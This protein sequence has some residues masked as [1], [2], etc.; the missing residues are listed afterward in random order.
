LIV[1]DKEK[2]IRHSYFDKKGKPC[3]HV[4][5]KHHQVFYTCNENGYQTSIQA[6][7]KNFTSTNGHLDN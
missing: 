7:D 1:P 4:F 6:F 2:L 3:E 5:K